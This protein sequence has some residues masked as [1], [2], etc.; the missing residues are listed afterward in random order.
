MKGTYG[1]RLDK[2]LKMRDKSRKE[3]A[4]CLGISVQAIG[5][6]INGPTVALTAENHEK[7]A[8]FL[9]VN[10][11]WLATGEGDSQPLPAGWPFPRLDAAK[12]FSLSREDLI[13][14]ETLLLRE[15]RHENIDLA[16][17]SAQTSGAAL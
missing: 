10:G 6:V 15:A 7:A 16:V 8:R 12:V 14:I 4:D 9:R 3:L 2:S 17:D 13:R 1:S 5:Q 11:Y